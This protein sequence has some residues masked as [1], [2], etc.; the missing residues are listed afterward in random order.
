[1]EKMLS[2]LLSFL[3]I[4]LVEHYE[5]QQSLAIHRSIGKK[6]VDNMPNMLVDNLEIFTA[7]ETWSTLIYKI[8][9]GCR[10]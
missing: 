7:L 3:T 9:G 4:R 10:L 2:P 1:M 5:V 8:A 6:K